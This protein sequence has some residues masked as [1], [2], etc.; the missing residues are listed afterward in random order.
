MGEMAIEAV[1]SHPYYQDEA[2]C[3]QIADRCIDLD[4][5]WA[6]LPDDRAVLPPEGDWIIVREQPCT[7]IPDPPL[8]SMWRAR[9]VY[10]ARKFKRVRAGGRVREVT[11]PLV[12]ARI[13]TPYGELTLLPREYLRVN[14]LAKWVGEIGQGVTLNVI[15]PGNPGPELNEKTFY[16]QSHGLRRVDAL[17]LLLPEVADQE[18][19]W[20]SL[21]GTGAEEYVRGAR[22]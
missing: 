21:D 10:H 5:L 6:A 22:A 20:L 2:V 15:G 3:E 9:P 8:Y 11:W 1:L 4:T 18:F 13:R 14:D 17:T 12:R 19:A 16:L 7:N